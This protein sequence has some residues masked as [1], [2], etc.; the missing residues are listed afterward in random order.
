MLG[1]MTAPSPT[2]IVPPPANTWP[3]FK[4][5][6]IVAAATVA[7]DATGLDM[8]VMHW[9]GSSGGFSLRNEWLLERVLH[10]GLREAAT[11]V[12][13]M[14]WIW[15]L[16]PARWHRGPRPPLPRRERWAVLG[17][18]SASL[19]LVSL[20]KHFSLTSCPWDL[21]PFGGVAWPVSHWQLGTADGG[22]G[23][24]F[25]GGH[26]STGFGF[27]AMALPWFAAPKD[28]PREKRIGRWWLL[29]SLGCGL[30]AGLVQTLRGAHFPSHTLWTLLICGGV[31]L[32]VWHAM[33]WVWSRPR[34]RH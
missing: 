19:A 18:V 20:L 28:S 21:K 16:W 13:L 5:W 29:G 6:L 1:S 30:L 34:R 25:P 32:A 26:A 10:T 15:T 23:H 14:L 24:C 33:R 12:Y 31:S 11:A 7:W 8:V 22:P 2:F 3:L 17:A 9:I 27:L 4:A